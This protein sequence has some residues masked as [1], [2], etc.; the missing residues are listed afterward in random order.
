MFSGSNLDH[1]GAKDLLADVLNDGEIVRRRFLPI[2]YPGGGNL[3]RWEE[4]RDE[5]MHVN[6]WFLADPMDMDR[7]KNLLNYLIA[8]QYLIENQRWYRARLMNSDV[9]YPLAEMGAPP[10]HLARHGRANPAGIPYLYLGST[11][12]T[13]VA[14]LR[15]HTGEHACVAEFTLSGSGLKFADLRDPRGLTSPLIGDESD[16]IRL[17]ADLSFLERLG[18]ELTRPVQPSGAPYEYIPTQYLCE[19]MKTCGF[20]GVLYRSSVSNDNGINLALFN[21]D[22]ANA[23][24]VNRVS[25]ERVSVQIS[26]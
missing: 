12:A 26:Q 14:E 6:R 4:L 23:T 25:V 11:P 19:F 9:V 7:I 22:S 17:R 20:D 13:A 5:M 16:V 24:K 10:R 21:P 1:A 3:K 15:P 18:E 8:Q 2:A